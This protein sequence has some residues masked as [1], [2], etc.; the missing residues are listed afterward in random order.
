MVS[1]CN[2]VTSPTVNTASTGGARAA[3]PKHGQL[4]VGT[5][6]KSGETWKL[7]DLPKNLTSTDA[8]A[9][10]GYFFQPLLPDQPE[11]D[12]PA[13]AAGNVSAEMK[14]LVEDLERLDKQILSAKPAEQNRLNASRA[15]LLEKVIT[16]A[17]AGD[18]ALWTRQY[19]ET[20]AAAIQTGAFHEGIRR[21]QC[22]SRYRTKEGWHGG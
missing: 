2:R 15:D 10:G 8:T 5:L 18:R 22:Q 12:A 11:A 9:S 3:A 20:V 16:A 17:P 7:F 13:A 21:L 14:K 4:M 19:T 6:I 1:S